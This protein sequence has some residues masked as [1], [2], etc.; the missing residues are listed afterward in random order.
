MWDKL[1]SWGLRALDR[2]GAPTAPHSGKSLGRAVPGAP[3]PH[4][5]HRG[6]RCYLVIWKSNSSLLP[7]P[8]PAAHKEATV[9]GGQGRRPHRA[10]RE[11]LNL[12]LQSIP[13]PGAPLQTRGQTHGQGL[14]GARAPRPCPRG[15]PHTHRH[16]HTHHI[17]PHKRAHITYSHRHTRTHHINTHSLTYARA[18]I[19]PTCTLAYTDA[20][21]SHSH[22]RKHAHHTYMHAHSHIHNS[23]ARTHVHTYTRTHRHAHRHIH[24]HAHRH[25]HARTHRPAGQAGPVQP[26]M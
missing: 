16:T 15:K 3:C 9:P 6:G 24:S 26:A 4:M 21:T 5:S 22:A 19:L 2:R 12:G 25:A 20:H 18:H 8:S 1:G 14:R 7:V 13:G 17:H 23:Y 11:T 10:T